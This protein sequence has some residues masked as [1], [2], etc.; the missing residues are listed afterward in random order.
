MMRPTRVVGG[1]ERAVSGALRLVG[2][3]LLLA[4]C[5][6]LDAANESVSLGT[7]AHGSLQNGVSLPP[8]GDGFVTYSRLGNW[9]GRQYVNSRVRDT[10]LSAFR[11]LHA[12]RPDR[13]YVVG[14]TGL[15]AG[16]VFPPHRSHQ[17]GLSADIFMPVRNDAG[18]RVLMPTP[19]WTKFGYALE[20]DAHGRGEGLS[21]DFRSLAELLV[22][23][24]RE[25]AGHGL[26]V[27]RIIVA[28]EYV[29]RVLAADGGT[30]ALA[31]RF[32]RRP[33]WVRHD[34][35][36]HVDFRVVPDERSRR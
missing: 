26:A 28:P 34:E 25:A 14:E 3:A 19:V 2:T 1:S 16:G 15:P 17:N 31:G 12:A 11:A 20:F 29:D 13:V 21:I 24:D 7:P 33:A 32:M 10:L 30:K 36:V 23:L 8:E 4:A 35:H 18:Q 6:R 5:P 9:L 27:E 22:E